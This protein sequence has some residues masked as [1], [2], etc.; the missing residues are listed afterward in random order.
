MIK[1]LFTPRDFIN[2]PDKNIYESA[3]YFQNFIAQMDEREVNAFDIICHTRTGS[4]MDIVDRYS[5]NTIKTTSYVTNNYLGTNQHPEVIKAAI[6]AIEKYGTGTCASPIIGGHIDLHVELEEKL[7]KLHDKEDAILFSSGYSA[8]IG[9]FQFLLS[10]QDIAIV[11]MFVHASIFDGLGCTNIKMFK[12]NDMDYLENTLKST[13]NKYRNVSIVVDGVYSQD[14]DLP[15]LKEICDL[16]QR[17]GALVFVD[18]AHGV[19]VF[20]K[21]GKGTVNHFGVENKVDLITGTFSKSMGTSGGY[22][23]G[24]RQLIK[25]MKHLSRASTFSASIAPPNTAAASRAI[26]LFTEEPGIIEKLWDNTRYIK[27][28]LSQKGF[29][30]GHSESPITPVMI[31]DDMKTKVIA[32]KLLEK[33]I[34]IIPATYPAV[35]LKNSRLRLNI[36]A[37]HTKKDLNYFSEALSDIDKTLTF[38]ANK[39]D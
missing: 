27:K 15:K 9:A 38:K 37:L 13:K 18:D 32:R 2:I 12:H 36:T 5:G 23:V 21:G 17:Y 30:I 14:G 20:G 35:K 10:K 7:A 16:A 31:R 11:D 24:S 34:Y 6:K 22:A 19:G 28:L 25:H 33:G 3:D 1:K 39:P 8:N 29:D 4:K 26:D